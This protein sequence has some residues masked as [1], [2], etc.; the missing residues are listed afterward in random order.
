MG[1]GVGSNLRI[2]KLK[3][4]YKSDA[5]PTVLLGPAYPMELKTNPYQQKK[6]FKGKRGNNE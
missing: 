5:W 4:N 3:L 2:P 1:P 6:N